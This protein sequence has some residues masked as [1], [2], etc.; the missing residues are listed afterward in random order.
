MNI[1]KIFIII[2][3]DLIK[4]SDSENC[5]SDHEAYEVKGSSKLGKYSRAAVAV[6]NEECSRIGKTILLKGG[7]AVDAAIAASL[8]NGV[9]NSHSMGIGGGCVIIIYSKLEFYLTF[10]IFN[11]SL[12]ENV[13][14]HLVL[15]NVKLLLYI[16]IEKCILK[17]KIFLLLVF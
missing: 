15:L 5:G 7:K 12:L 11:Y 9:L 8:C 10:S 14:K 2:K 3:L 17:K 13:E 6:D 1:C 16:L 4:N